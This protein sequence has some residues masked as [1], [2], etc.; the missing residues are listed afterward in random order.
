MPFECYNERTAR[1]AWGDG[2]PVRSAASIAAVAGLMRGGVPHFF[3]AARGGGQDKIEVMSI[4]IVNAGS[5]SVK[6]SLFEF[7]ARVE[8]ASGS[9]DW[10]DP[11]RRPRLVVRAG[12]NVVT[13]VDCDA[14]NHRAG[15]VA[16]L[17]SLADVDHVLGGESARIEA[18]GHRVVHGGDVF[19]ASV[20]IDERVRAA[21]AR[22]A[23]LAP[24]HNLAA[25]EAIDAARE[26]L[27]AAKHVAAFD[28]AYYSNLPET[29][30]TYPLPL[31]W[32]DDWGIRRYGFH[33]LS[34]DYSNGRA[35]ELLHNRD[36]LRVVSCHLGN[37]CSATAARGGVAIDTT[38]GY[39]PLEGLMM[40]TRAGSV[41][42]GILIETM[43]TRGLTADDLDRI[44]NRESGLL[45]VSG[46]ASD[47]RAVEAAAIAGNARA[48]LA[49][50]LFA[51]RLRSAIG[52]LA[53][54]LGGVDAL[55]FTGGIGEHAASLRA[56]ACAGL[57][58]LGIKLDARKNQDAVGAR[59]CDVADDDSKA[60]VLVVAAREDLVIAREAR[61]ILDANHA[62]L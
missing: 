34:H 21:I 35:A 1:L 38:M 36:G 3:M 18:V 50:D 9:I 23:E 22:L 58:C 26:S 29:S 56:Q 47:V 33:G 62:N 55:V 25:L 60:R 2:T 11:T 49:L 43:R 52:A 51:W 27:P 44:L 30:K 16:A 4:L 10:T 59:D 57:E 45:G 8:S 61:L 7:D 48:R 15:V 20:L 31:S 37:G 39:T 40:G 42:A 54:T 5:S 14:S 13:S 46:V 24:L 41:D 28:T 32:R 6:F 53:V 12:E 17:R 19:H